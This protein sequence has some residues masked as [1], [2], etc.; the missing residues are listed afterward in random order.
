MAGV[1][2]D[3]KAGAK[4]VLAEN[5]QHITHEGAVLADLTDEKATEKVWKI[6]SISFHVDCDFSSELILFWFL[7][8]D[9]DQ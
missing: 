9:V 3:P 4:N 5:L 7:N 6:M 2:T 1:G 8:G